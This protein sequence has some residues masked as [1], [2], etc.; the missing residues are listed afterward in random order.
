MSFKNGRYKTPG[1]DSTISKLVSNTELAGGVFYVSSNRVFSSGIRFDTSLNT[2]EDTDFAIALA[3]A[4]M[5]NLTCHNPYMMEMSAISILSTCEGHR[6]RLNHESKIKIS[7]K[8]TD[9]FG[10]GIVDYDGKRMNLRGLK[11]F[12][13]KKIY[14]DMKISK[15]A[16]FKHEILIIYIPKTHFQV[17]S[18][19]N[20]KSK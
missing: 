17:P 4:G 19:W 15:I 12:I 16:D 9:I 5:T 20:I 18:I 6:R 7:K 13:I 3:H 2:L 8:W 1:E 14:V 11:N 10:P